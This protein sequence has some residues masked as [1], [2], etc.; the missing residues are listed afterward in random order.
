MQNLGLGGIF[1][2]KDM[3]VPTVPE[4]NSSLRPRMIMPTTEETK[5]N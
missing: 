5:R 2:P 4:T 3:G 1:I